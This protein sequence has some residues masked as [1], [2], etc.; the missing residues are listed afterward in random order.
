MEGAPMGPAVG[1]YLPGLRPDDPGH[2]VGGRW[3]K[4]RCPSALWPGLQP[5]RGKNRT[6]DPGPFVSGGGLRHGL[7]PEGGK[8]D[9]LARRCSGAVLCRYDP[10]PSVPHGNAG[11]PLGLP[12]GRKRREPALLAHRG[13]VLVWGG[14][15]LL[16]APEP[17]PAGPGAHS[18]VPEAD[19]A[20]GGGVAPVLAAHLDLPVSRIYLRGYR[21]PNSAIPRGYAL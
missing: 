14:A 3:G 2:S 10:H 20:V 18:S 9:I 11:K 1:R 5:V 7:G 16:Q 12:G 19:A 13:A 6:A 4:R 21:C 8:K 15:A 17:A